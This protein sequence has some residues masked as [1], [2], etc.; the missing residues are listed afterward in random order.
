MHKNH[1]EPK[2]TLDVTDESFVKYYSNKD[3]LCW[4]IFLLESIMSPEF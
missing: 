4:R 2:M 1:I 3:F